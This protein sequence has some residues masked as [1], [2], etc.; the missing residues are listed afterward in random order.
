MFEQFLIQ[1]NPMEIIFYVEN[2]EEEEKKQLESILKENGCSH[3]RIRNWEGVSFQK[4]EEKMDRCF[5]NNWVNEC[6]LPIVVGKNSSLFELKYNWVNELKLPIVSGK[7]VRLLE[8][9][10]NWV[11][12][13]KLMR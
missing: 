12:E 4:I 3:V 10:N 5:L 13:C 1:Y 11:N 9:K 7:K 6:K 2:F 8:L